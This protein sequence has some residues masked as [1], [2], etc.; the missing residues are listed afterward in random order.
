MLFVFQRYLMLTDI[1]LIIQLLNLINEVIFRLSLVAIGWMI[2][3]FVSGVTFFK[4]V[5][6]IA[7]CLK[8]KKD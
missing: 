3:G 1:T 5:R 6:N 4:C 7:N 2:F 8:K